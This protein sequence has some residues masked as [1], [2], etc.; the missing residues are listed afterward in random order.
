MKEHSQPYFLS[1]GMEVGLRDNHT[2]YLGASP[3]TISSFE[4]VDPLLQIFM[5]VIPIEVIRTSAF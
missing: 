3:T 1:Q 2:V 4:A 5:S